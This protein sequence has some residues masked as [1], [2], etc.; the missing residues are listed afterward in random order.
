MSKQVLQLAYQLQQVL[1]P[2]I[3]SAKIVFVDREYFLNFA[4]NK[5]SY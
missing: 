4:A 5:A 1:S 3:Y 2:Q